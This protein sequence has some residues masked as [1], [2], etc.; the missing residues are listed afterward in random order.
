MPLDTGTRLGPY[1]IVSPLGTGGMGEVYKARDTRLD[2]T[3]AI[4]VSK[5]NFSERFEREAR[6]IAALN[7]PHVCQL[8]DVGPNYLVM[9][10]V[11]GTPL[12]GPLSAGDALR[13]AT[14]I[15]DA[16]D[17]AHRKGIVHRDLKPANILITRKG[18]PLGSPGVKLLDFGLARIA[19][20]ANDPTL[21]SAGE[22]MGTP[23]YMAPE[24]WEGKPADVR[25]DIYAFGCVLY[26]MLTGK[27]AAQERAPVESPTLEHVLRGCLAKDPEDRWQSAR[28]L[29]HAL[30]LPA[31]ASVVVRRPWRAH[32][33]WAMVATALL[34]A[35]VYLGLS[36]SPET[37]RVTR[38]SVYPPGKSVFSVPVFVTVGHPQFA[39]SPDGRSM[40]Y[41]AEASGA[42]PGI[43]LRSFDNTE[44]RS[45]PGTEN[46]EY[47][48]WSP[49]NAS[50]GF[51]ADGQVKKV[52]VAGGPVQVVA[53]VPDPRGGSWGP[54]DTILVGTGSS[55]IYRA[56]ANGGGA[57]PLTALDSSAKEGSHRWPDLLPDGRHFI[58]TV[59]SEDRSRLGVYVASLDGKAKKLLARND[60]NARYLDPGFLL[61]MDGGTLVG[62]PFDVERLEL[63]GRSF[64]IAEQVG[65]ASNGSGSFSA[66][67]AG[68]LAYAAP[69]P[70]VARLTWFDREGRSLGE[71]GPEG[72]Y[73]DFRLSPDEKRLAASLV[74]PSTGNPD[75][76]LT[77]LERGTAFPLT[78]G[79][80][81]NAGP[82]WSPD[83]SRIVFRTT[84]RGGQVELYQKSSAG[85]GREEPLLLADV[86]RAAGSLG[87]N[88]A[89]QDWSPDGRQ[90]LYT[91]SG[92]F[93]TELWLLPVQD[94]K[95][96]R[97]LSSS[98]SS[99][100]ASFSPDGHV[101]AY[102]SD[103]SGKREVYAQTFPLS[104]QK[105]LISAGGGYEP[106]WRRDGREI[107]YLSTDRKLMAVAVGQGPSFGVPR[108]LFQTRVPTRITAQRIQYAPSSDGQRFLINTQS[109]DAEPTPITVVLNWRSGIAR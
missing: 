94:R 45:V 98:S 72:D 89:I 100:H 39:V 10:F 97:L 85:G 3:V 43:W 58:F 77:D 103:E 84:R 80:A 11:D 13:F 31:G 40:V 16:L 69:S 53:D 17:A 26:E 68:T 46:A 2:R 99:T 54:D 23:A 50:V 52:R 75:I 108:P 25:S 102:G 70:Q 41:V 6:A 76:W 35:A 59:R 93:G 88:M 47:P 95:P 15:C 21:T 30:E 22:V 73:S 71:V 109:G 60:S 37:A 79:P 87:L 4:K 33:A 66:A 7:H 106:R 104:D 24:Q 36:R 74:D 63:T 65:R 12:A 67:L 38:F 90:L 8:Y 61:F 1:E 19:A 44:P 107:F 96:V 81:I 28:D 18:G 101:V 49:D 92:S 27:R 51:F 64:V 14:E 5:E 105:L 56:S 55:V 32:A 42:R 78:R 82:I 57:E 86:Q 34:G 29:R 91:S 48:F 83:G 62:Q 9:E 20:G